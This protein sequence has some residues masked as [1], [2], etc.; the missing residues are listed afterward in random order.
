MLELDNEM[1]LIGKRIYQLR[2]YRN[3]TQLDIEV[4]CGIS[5][6]DISRIENGKQNFEIITLIKIANALKV[7]L[8][9]LFNYDGT[10]P[11]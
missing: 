5:N 4:A 1:I 7:A 8:F 9:E 11:E 6:A 2:K 3:L 10:L